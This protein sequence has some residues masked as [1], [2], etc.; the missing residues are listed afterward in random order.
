MVFQWYLLGG[1]GA[2]TFGL[3]SDGV[4]LAQLAK[5]DFFSYL[6]FI[7]LSDW[8]IDQAIFQQLNIKNP[9]GVIFSKWVSCFVLLGGNQYWIA[10]VYFSLL[11]FGGIWFLSNTILRYYPNYKT[12]VLL[13]FCYWPSVVFWSAGVI[14]EALLMACLCS[15]IAIFFKLIKEESKQKGVLLLYI[16]LL[17]LLSY[18][19][20]ILKYYYL[21][22][23]LP[24]LFAL[25]VARKVNRY[26]VLV[27]FVTFT[28]SI[29]LASFLHPNLHLNFV[30][31]AIVRNNQIMV[32]QTSDSSNLIH[33]TNLEANLASVAA[34]IPTAVFEGWA[35]P[36]LWEVGNIWKKIAAAETLLLT[37]LLLAALLPPY[38]IPKHDEQKLALLSIITFCGL[39]LI[40]LTLAA[41]NL[42]NLVRYKSTF[43]PFA[44]L[45]IFNSIQM[46]LKH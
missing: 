41:P 13:A 19:V 31:E 6:N 35:R 16:G 43:L 17:V 8:E 42:G 9:R 21:G 3:F 10:A 4:F 40:M 15:I 18:T 33:F 12:A 5:D 11:S 44:L 20:L 37:L 34:N 1:K 14:K 36:Y 26:Q 45:L 2:D 25:L 24:T 46:K 38:R 39:L 22:A 29:V 28:S 7:F 27:F 23:L 32:A 30:L